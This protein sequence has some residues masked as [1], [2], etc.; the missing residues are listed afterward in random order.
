MRCGIWENQMLQLQLVPTYAF[1]V[2]GLGDSRNEVWHL[3]LIMLEYLKGSKRELR[4]TILLSLSRNGMYQI[5]S[6]TYHTGSILYTAIGSLLSILRR[7]AITKYMNS[8]TNETYPFLLYNKWWA[9]VLA[10]KFS[11]P[12]LTNSTAPAILMCPM[13]MLF[14][15]LLIRDSWLLEW[16]HFPHQIYQSML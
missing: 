10:A 8:Y 5:S 13:T 3:P 16:K 2:S 6:I 4:F 1:H 11:G 9:V 7:S 15:F 12:F 14:F